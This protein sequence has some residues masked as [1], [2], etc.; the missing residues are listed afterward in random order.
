MVM[1]QAATAVTTTA[2]TAGPAIGV[3]LAYSML[4]FQGC[5]QSRAR[6]A[7]GRRPCGGYSGLDNAGA[8]Q[9]GRRVGLSWPVGRAM[10]LPADESTPAAPQWLQQLLSR[11]PGEGLGLDLGGS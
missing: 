4:W 8:S 10:N 9:Q 5:W 6:A 11:G 7:R 3:G 1:T 2:P